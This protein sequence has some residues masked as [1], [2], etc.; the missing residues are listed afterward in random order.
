M[1][2]VGLTRIDGID[3]TTVLKIVSE[4]GLDMN[5]WKSEKHFTS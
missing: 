4:I 1:I 2:G 3:S 5:H